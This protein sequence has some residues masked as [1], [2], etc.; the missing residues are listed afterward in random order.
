MS[1]ED[2]RDAPEPVVF[3]QKGIGKVGLAMVWVAAVMMAVHA[4]GVLTFAVSAGHVWPLVYIEVPLVVI[5]LNMM[6]LGARK[7]TITGDE[8]VV[9][10]VFTTLRL[11][12]GE[13]RAWSILNLLPTVLNAIRGDGRTKPIY[14]VRGPG[15]RLFA[16]GWW[17]NDYERA[18]EMMTTDVRE[19]PWM[20]H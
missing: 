15:P 18:V 19:V 13:M 17:I 2:V 10:K 4:V 1:A 5:G 11:R 3:H 8:V 14:F 6:N 7:V 16:I 20:V 12:R 9:R